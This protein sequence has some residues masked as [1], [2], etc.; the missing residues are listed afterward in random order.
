M[1]VNIISAAE[2]HGD[3]AAKLFEHPKA[4]IFG[5]DSKQQ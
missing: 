1:L 2:E 4:V 5:Q 3:E